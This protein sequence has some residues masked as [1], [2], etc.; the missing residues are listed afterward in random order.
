MDDRETCSKTDF[1]A[2]V[3]RIVQADCGMDMDDFLDFLQFAFQQ[4]QNLNSI[5][6]NDTMKDT[7]NAWRQNR[8][9][10]CIDDVQHFKTGS[11]PC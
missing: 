6:E 1:E 4:T 9:L 3:Q 8:I 2:L 7:A 5:A 10:Q 11:T